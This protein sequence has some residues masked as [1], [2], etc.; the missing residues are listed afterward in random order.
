MD[1]EQQAI[2]LSVYERVSRES[3]GSFKQDIHQ[4]IDIALAQP[5]QSDPERI[6]QY[7]LQAEAAISKPVMKAFKRTISETIMKA[8]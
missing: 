2:M 6:H 8:I 7:R 1:T 3:M 5:D 4:T